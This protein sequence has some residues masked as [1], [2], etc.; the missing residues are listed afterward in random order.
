MR[1]RRA[2]GWYGGQGAARGRAD[3][4]VEERDADVS[5]RQDVAVCEARL[6]HALLRHARPVRAAAILDVRAFGVDFDLR[7][8]AGHGVVEDLER[9]ARLAA[10]REAAAA[11][12]HRLPRPL[13]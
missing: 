6:D 11:D 8:L 1:G 3:P 9:V 2:A 12:G 13:A 10:D 4:R 5:E 7:V